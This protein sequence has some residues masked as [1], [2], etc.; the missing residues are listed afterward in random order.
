MH[1]IEDEL[2]FTN[3]TGYIFHDSRGFE[4]GGED[5]LNFVQ[6]FVRRKL[7]EPQLRDRLHAIWSVPFGIYP[8]KFTT[9]LI[10][11]CIPM[12]NVRPELDLRYFDDICPDKNGTSNYKFSL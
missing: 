6:E 8:S 1:D 3:H 5:E 7:R 11:Y 4:A 2:I 12:D 9:L 10:R